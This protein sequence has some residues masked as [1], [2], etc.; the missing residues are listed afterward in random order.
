MVYVY[1][2]VRFT[3]YCSNKGEAR[4]LGESFAD[5]IGG[6]DDRKNN[7]TQGYIPVAEAKLLTIF[8]L[9]IDKNNVRV[10]KLYKTL[11]KRLYRD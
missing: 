3:R 2:Y 11:N 4:Y 6:D 9:Y 7:W 5:I 8:A 10:N 1:N